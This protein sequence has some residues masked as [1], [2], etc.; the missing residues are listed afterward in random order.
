LDLAVEAAVVSARD[1]R[2]QPKKPAVMGN[3]LTR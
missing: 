2:G 1:G 3:T